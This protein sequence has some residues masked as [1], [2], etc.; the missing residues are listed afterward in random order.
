[1]SS[2]L[3][4]NSSKET[5]SKSNEKHKLGLFS[6][7][8]KPKESS[9]GKKNTREGG[10][11]DYGSKKLKEDSENAYSYDSGEIPDSQ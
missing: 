1:M 4:L 2:N 3:G 6:F 5:S 7:F 10:K 9:I 8:K 11:G